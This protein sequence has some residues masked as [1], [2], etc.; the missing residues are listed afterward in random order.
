MFELN[1]LRIRNHIQNFVPVFVQGLND[2]NNVVVTFTTHINLE[3]NVINVF[4]YLDL[5][6]GQ[7]HEKVYEFLTWDCSFGLN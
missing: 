5:L 6:K 4:F 3:N 1:I 2:K 7:S